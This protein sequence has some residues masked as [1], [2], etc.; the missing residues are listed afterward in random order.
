MVKYDVMLLNVCEIISLL[1]FPTLCWDPPTEDDLGR[2]AL[3]GRDAT[4][5]F[6][7][8]GSASL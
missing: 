8:C 7:A 2:A 6:G 3:L 4:F 1:A 5:G